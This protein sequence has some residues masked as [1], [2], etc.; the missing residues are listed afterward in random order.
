MEAGSKKG[1]LR[2]CVSSHILNWIKMKIMLSLENHPLV[3]SMPRA[4]AHSVLKP[5]P[6]EGNKAQNV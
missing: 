4:D 3:V 2:K 5:N 6:H 1:S